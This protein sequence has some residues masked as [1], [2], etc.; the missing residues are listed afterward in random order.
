M[1]KDCF[2]SFDN[3][4]DQ[5]FDFA[6]AHF[7]LPFCDSEAKLAHF[8]RNIYRM[9]K[10]GGKCFVSG[11]IFSANE[12]DQQKT[13]NVLRLKLPLR[14]ETPV[15]DPFFARLPVFTAPTITVERKILFQLPCYLWSQKKLFQLFAETG[16]IHAKNLSTADAPIEKSRFTDL[17]ESLTE[18]YI[19]LGAVKPAAPS[20]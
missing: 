13:I 6:A 16:F 19:F 14:P 8:C 11:T 1:V 3:Q 12:Y 9:L 2:Q 5:Q 10:P 18:P 4:F 7:L 20:K 17:F 15:Q